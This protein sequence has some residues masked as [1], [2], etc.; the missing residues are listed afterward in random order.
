MSHVANNVSIRYRACIQREREISGAISI[1]SVATSW[2]L[3]I[4]QRTIAFTR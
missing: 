1:S 4:S 3:W 2:R